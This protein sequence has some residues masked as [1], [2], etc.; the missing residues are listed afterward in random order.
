MRP[1]A[2][3]ILVRRNAI[4]TTPRPT[5]GRFAESSLL[6]TAVPPVLAHQFGIYCVD[7]SEQVVALTYDDGPHPEHTP[8]LLDVL[9]ELG[10]TATFFVLGRQVERHPEVARRILAEGHEVALHGEDHRSLM[11]LGDREAVAI[12]RQ[13][14]DRV[15]SVISAPLHLYRPPY[16][17]HTARQAAGIARLGLDL[18]I[19]SGDAHDWLHDDESRIAERAAEE[20]FPG[21]IVLL[22]DDRGDPETITPG[23]ELPHFDRAS[24]LRM[25]LADL[26][27]RGFRTATVS[28]LLADHQPVRSRSRQRRGSR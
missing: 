4:D 7:T 23:E 19:W 18:V 14:R 6:P 24:V 27:S 22:H 2:W 1:T 28:R 5:G 11:T 8:R 10:A 12:I 15:Q 3:P 16:G 21:G 17:V 9:G 26:D 20:T 25:L 13:A